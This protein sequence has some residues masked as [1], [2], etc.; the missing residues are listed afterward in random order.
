MPRTTTSHFEDN[1]GD[2]EEVITSETDEFIITRVECE[3][4]LKECQFSWFS[5]ENL[6]ARALIDRMMD[7]VYGDRFVK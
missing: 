5:Y 6:V 3:A 4:L 7:F 2:N 1:D